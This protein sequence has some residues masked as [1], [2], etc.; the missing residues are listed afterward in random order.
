MYRT[1]LT[2][3]LL[4]ALVLAS[5]YVVPLLGA[6]VV[7]AQSGKKCLCSNEPAGLR[8]KI[9]VPAYFNPSATTYWKEMDALNEHAQAVGIA[10]MNPHNGPG[11]NPSDKKG[12]VKNPEYLDAVQNAR[13][14]GIKVYGY[15][16]TGRGQR[17]TKEV[18]SDINKYADY[19]KVNDIF[20]DEVEAN[21]KNVGYYQELAD[22]IHC[23]QSTPGSVKH[24]CVQG[25]SV[26]LNPGVIPDD[27]KY[28]IFSD[29]IVVFENSFKE[30]N[31]QKTRDDFENSD[32]HPWLCN[33]GSEKYAHLVHETKQSD[34]ETALSLSKQ[35]HAGY[36]YF[37]DDQCL[38]V[39]DKCTA[40]P[41]DTLPHYLKGKDSEL[42]GGCSTSN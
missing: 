19:Y 23:V 41:W 40:N 3:L 21:T 27:E 2:I 26:I 29:I 9:I 37:T 7:A 14:A 34:L 30:Y 39:N 1:R 10:I 42:N 16:L 33:H 4:L 12:K 36:V 31:T 22:Y 13:A 25:A 18:I 6:K 28:V 8:Q 11:K 20:L 5:S 32:K 17:K 35:L 24:D 38:Q 15:V